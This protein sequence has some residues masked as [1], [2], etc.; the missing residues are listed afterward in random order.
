M[1]TLQ[2]PSSGNRRPSMTQSSLTTIVPPSDNL[3]EKA[4]LQSQDAAE[5]RQTTVPSQG[6]G[7]STLEVVLGEKGTDGVDPSDAEEGQTSANEEDESQYPKGFKLFLICLALC[8]V[9]FL[10]AL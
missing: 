5:T 4:A 2:P 7:S 3:S 9:V 1:T 6:S 8:L 10:I